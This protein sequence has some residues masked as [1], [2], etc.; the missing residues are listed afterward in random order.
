[1]GLLPRKGELLFEKGVLVGKR[2]DMLG[3]GLDL[4]LG[5][6]ELGLVELVAGHSGLK[7]DHFLTH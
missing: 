5:L 7:F 4:L 1:M 2:L 6:F 3:E